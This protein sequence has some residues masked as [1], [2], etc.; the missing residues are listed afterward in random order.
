MIISYFRTFLSALVLLVSLPAAAQ[1]ESG[2]DQ[3]EQKSPAQL[4]AADH[5]KAQLQRLEGQLLAARQSL[6]QC[7]SEACP[8]FIR[9][10]CVRWL[11]EVRQETPSVIL[12]A[13]GDDGPLTDV[14]VL[15]DGEV[16]TESLTGKTIPLDPGPYTFEFVSPSGETREK[17]VLLHQG[18][19]HA[20]VEADFRSEEE[21]V[22]AGVTPPGPRDS[23]V[24]THR[25][26]P[27]SAYIAGGV[28]VAALAS[29]AVFGIIAKNQEGDALETCAPN[30]GA[31]VVDDIKQK[32]L[33]AD[34][35]LGVGAAAAATAAVLYFTRPTVQK[36]ET[37]AKMEPSFA[38]GPG[39]AFLG[40]KGTF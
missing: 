8:S 29:F 36:Q 7:A 24:E 39:G 35:S 31:P 9:N 12:E 27:V 16:L 30:C 28:T 23:G 6:L 2:D 18:E 21:L 14:Q 15:V 17:K 20:V 33:I 34:I 32:A 13:K 25:P 3:D 4:C 37:A 19:R 40:M 38:V 26:I 11:E 10:D 1:Q 5:E 22:A